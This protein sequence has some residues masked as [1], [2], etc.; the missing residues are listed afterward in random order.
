VLAEPN[1]T[2]TAPAQPA[3][4]DDVHAL[5]EAV[6]AAHEDVQAADRMHFAIAVTEVAGNIVQHAGDGDPLEF[7]LNIGVDGEALTAEFQ[8]PGRRLDVDLTTVGLPGPAAES[9]RGLALAL[10]CVDSLEYRREAGTNRWRLVRR[11]TD[12]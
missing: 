7:T 9:G 3:S 12:G 2:L 1:G 5:L 8:D 10:L 4:M 11:R 6:W